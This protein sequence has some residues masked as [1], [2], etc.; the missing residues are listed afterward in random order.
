MAHLDPYISGLTGAFKIIAIIIIFYITCRGCNAAGSGELIG[1]AKTI[2]VKVTVVSNLSMNRYVAII[3]IGVVGYIA[4]GRGTCGCIDGVSGIAE[5]ITV[6]ITVIG[7]GM[8]QFIAV[9]AI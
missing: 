8:N 2:T 1:I 7:N 5:T 9:I 3:T 6:K 4:C